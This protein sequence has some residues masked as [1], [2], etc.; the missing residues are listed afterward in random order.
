MILCSPSPGTSGPDSTIFK[1]FHKG[2]SA[3]FFWT[4][5]SRWNTKRSMNAVPGVIQ[6]ESNPA[7]ESGSRPFEWFILSLLSRDSFA[8]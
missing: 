6:F 7:A 1:S 8:S 5:N 3:I 2:S 4:K